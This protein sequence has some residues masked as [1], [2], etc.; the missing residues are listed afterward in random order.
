MTW[1]SEIY[2]GCR[3]APG[4]VLQCDHP[5][6]VPVLQSPYEH[7]QEVDE[8]EL[9]ES[10]EDRHEANDDEN[11]QSSGIAD[12][13]FCLSSEANGD[14]SQDSGGSQLCSGW[15]LL[16]LLCLDEPESDPGTH[17][18]DVQ[19]NVDLQHTQSAHLATPLSP[20]DHL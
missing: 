11:I 12:L 7:V 16:A 15:R 4:H 8:G 10:R 6:K 20:W 5:H 9:N 18:D 13:R 1:K 14:N 3:H 17:D 19:G 2:Q